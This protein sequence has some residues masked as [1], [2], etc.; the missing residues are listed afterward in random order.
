MLR[1][2]VRNPVRNPVR[3]AA[4][5]RRRARWTETVAV[6]CFRSWSYCFT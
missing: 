6:A 1:A 5:A 2:A 4:Q 3:A